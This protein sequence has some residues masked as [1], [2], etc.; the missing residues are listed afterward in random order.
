MLFEFM[1]RKIYIKKKK[2]ANYSHVIYVKLSSTGQL[3]LL[4]ATVCGI[5]NQ[6]QFQLCILPITIFSAR[7]RVCM[8]IEHIKYL[9]KL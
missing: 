2:S 9:G 3:M 8:L 1:F 4:S 7:F 5:L 6:L